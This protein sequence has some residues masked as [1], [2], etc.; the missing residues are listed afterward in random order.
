M[1]EE[2]QIKKLKIA[3][4]TITYSCV[5]VAAY[6]QRWKLFHIMHINI[7]ATNETSEHLNQE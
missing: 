2:K 1:Q 3:K 7:S 5:L 6:S 4:Y